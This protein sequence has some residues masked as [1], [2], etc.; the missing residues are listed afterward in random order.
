[1]FLTQTLPLAFGQSGP[2]VAGLSSAAQG[3]AQ[4]EIVKQQ[5]QQAGLN[6]LANTFGQLGRTL[7]AAFR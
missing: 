4:L 3:G 2:A 7:G 5:Q 6:A 1:M